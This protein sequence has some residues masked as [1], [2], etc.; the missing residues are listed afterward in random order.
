[1]IANLRPEVYCG[2]GALEKQ[3]VE[4]FFQLGMKPFMRLAL[5]RFLKQA[6][7]DCFDDRRIYCKLSPDSKLISAS[8]LS[9]FAGESRAFALRGAKTA[10]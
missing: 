10:T 3:D 9:C 6:G 1:V 2:N 5:S 7:G 8:C 4:V